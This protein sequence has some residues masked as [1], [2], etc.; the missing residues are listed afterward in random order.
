[1]ARTIGSTLGPFDRVVVSDVPRTMETALVMGFS[2]NEVIAT[3]HGDGIWD[4]FCKHDHW[5]WTEPFVRY[6]DLIKESRAL[7]ELGQT[8]VEC[9]TNVLESASSS[10]SVLV[11]SHGHL[12][13]VAFVTCFEDRDLAK[14]GPA[15]SHGEGFRVTYDN[16]QFNDF[17]ILRVGQDF[18]CPSTRP[19]TDSEGSTAAC[20]SNS[21][22]RRQWS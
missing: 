12:M 13:E 11:I 7:A 10:A 17:E 22:V 21:G 8:L 16:G 6:R 2:V 3:S 4:A 14:I 9:W 5:A 1:M 19:P 15:F 20:L 18:R